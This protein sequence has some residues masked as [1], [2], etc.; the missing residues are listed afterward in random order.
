M[1]LRSCSLI[2]EAAATSDALGPGAPAD[3]GTA[4]IAGGVLGATPISASAR[5][6]VA[7]HGASAGADFSIGNARIRS[8][9]SFRGSLNGREILLV[10]VAVTQKEKV[11]Q[12]GPAFESQGMPAEEF[13]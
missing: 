10:V 7:T 13:A 6:T 8:V 1:V 3:G 4:A 2:C 5:V 9:A 12:P 11:I